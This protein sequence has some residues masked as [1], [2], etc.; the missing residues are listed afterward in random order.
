MTDGMS[1]ADLAAITNNEGF[2]NGS[3]F[4]IVVLFLFGF[5]G[6]GAWG[7]SN[8]AT[9]TEVQN[10]FNTQN[11]MSRFDTISQN[12]TQ[13]AYENANLINKAIYD[14]A[15]LINNANVNNMQSIYN[16]TNAMN[17]GFNSVN[18]SLNDGFNSVNQN[19]CNISHQISDGVCA[20][21]TQMLQ[22]K[23]DD[24]LNSYNQ[25]VAANTN[26]VQ[27]QNILGALGRWVANPPYPY[28]YYY[29]TTAT[30]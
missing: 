18:S 26:A 17:Q 19:L 21:K 8:T 23:Y 15:T 28:G 12:Q 3:W 10:G 24:L 7:N 27:T 4:W 5:M 29:G 25:S 30:V 13:N 9:S 22:D 1:A 14:N 6:N 2:G 16:M 11:I 20:I